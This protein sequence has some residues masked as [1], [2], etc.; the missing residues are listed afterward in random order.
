MSP[1]YAYAG[2]NASSRCRILSAC[3]HAQSCRSGA[4]RQLCSLPLA[5]E[6]ML[7][8]CAGM[9]LGEALDSAF[10]HRISLPA[11]DAE[12]AGAPI[13]DTAAVPQ[14]DPAAAHHLQLGPG[15]MEQEGTTQ[16]AC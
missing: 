11:D 12:H 2:T 4:I 5:A 8:S 3:R 13:T 1:A 16:P 14:P 10:A 6:L 15:R 7:C 9:S